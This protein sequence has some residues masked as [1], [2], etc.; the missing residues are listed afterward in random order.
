[1]TRKKRPG[2]GGSPSTGSSEHP[3]RDSDRL[4]GSGPKSLAVETTP[5]DEEAAL[6]AEVRAQLDGRPVGQILV[7]LNP[8][9]RGIVKDA[10]ALAR[11][12]GVPLA[13]VTTSGE[14]LAY[15]TPE[16]QD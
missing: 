1:M 6:E 4:N 5:T 7:V 12:Y 16:D 9:H 15:R 10:A 3:D 8:A 14:V 11:I 13:I 2:A